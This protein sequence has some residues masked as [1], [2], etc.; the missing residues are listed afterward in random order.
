MEYNGTITIEEYAL[1]F[2]KIS[3]NTVTVDDNGTLIET[4]SSK[5]SSTY[6]QIPP[7]KFSTYVDVPLVYEFDLI[8]ASNYVVCYPMQRSDNTW[9]AS[10]SLLGHIKLE[11]KQ[12]NFK[13][14][15]NGNLLSNVD[16][17]YLKSK[18]YFQSARDNGNG[19]I[20]FKNLKIY[21]L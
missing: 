19:Y 20:K 10:T 18:L 17:T 15:Q 13:A 6:M 8:E 9:W 5:Y 4:D 12:D 16:G 3:A 7:L 14:Y 2:P 21:S 11:I 1:E